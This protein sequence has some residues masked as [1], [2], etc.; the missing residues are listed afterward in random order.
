MGFWRRFRVFLFGVGLGLLFVYAVFGDRDVTAWFPERKILRAI[1]SSEVTITER[2]FCQLRCNNFPEEDLSNLLQGADIDFWNSDTRRKPC[3][4]YHITSEDEKVFM[5]WE[6]CEKQ[7]TAELLL[8]KTDK[9]C[10][11]EDTFLSE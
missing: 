8:F 7:K 10:G 11:C 1:D 4:H 6:V 2:A 9:N 5:I 3:P